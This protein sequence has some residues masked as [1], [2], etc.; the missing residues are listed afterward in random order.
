MFVKEKIGKGKKIWTQ[1]TKD[2]LRISL[3][4]CFL[5]ASKEKDRK[6]ELFLPISVIK[7]IMVHPSKRKEINFQKRGSL[8]N[9]VHRLKHDGSF[10]KRGLLM[11]FPNKG[12]FL[13]V[14]K[15][16]HVMVFSTYTGVYSKK[17]TCA[18]FKKEKL[19]PT[20]PYHVPLKRPF[21]KG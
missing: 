19:L 10:K 12:N 11:V 6:M 1:V 13:F 15:G 3:K 17:C 8:K 7:T 18:S 14:S 16:C 5:P 2:K 4:G 21:K 20:W 9:D